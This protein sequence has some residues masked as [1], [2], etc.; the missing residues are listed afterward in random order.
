M[1]LSPMLASLADAP[2]DDPNLVY[3]PKYD[4]IRA[5][6]EVRAVEGPPP[7]DKDRRR[8]EARLWSRRG[9]D[10]TPEFPAVA[11]AL[12]E[13]A[14]R[15]GVPLVLD[16]EI[17]A[18][19]ER[20]EPAGFQ[21]LQRRAQ[22]SPADVALIVFDLLRE[23]SAD[24]RDLP[25]VERRARLERLITSE[26]TGKSTLR[27]SEMTRGNGRELYS[28]ARASGWE[29]IIAKQASSPYRSGKRTPEW[30]K[31]KIVFEQEFVIGG[32]TEPRQTRSHFGALLLGVYEGKTRRF[33]R[34][35]SRAPG[36]IHVGLA[37]TGFDEREL[38]RVMKCLRPLETTVCPFEEKPRTEERAHWIR[39]ELVAQVKFTEWTADGRLRN[40]VYLGLRDDR[41]PHQIMREAT[42]RP[43]ATVVRLAS[44]P[45]G[46]EVSSTARDRLLD[47]LREIEDSRRDSV[48]DLPN[49]GKLAVTNLSKIFWP[50]QQFTKGDLVRY[51][52]EV[53]P[54]ILPA[55][56][57]RPLVMKR[58]PNGI[59][60]KAFYQHQ[61]SRVPPGVRVEQVVPSSQDAQIAGGDLMTLLYT[62]QLAAVSQDPWFSRV[63]SPQYPD[64]VALDLD[65]MP[66]VPFAGVLDVARWI[67]DELQRLDATGFAKTSGSE[68][69]HVYIPL[70]PG[71]PYEAG[72]LFC[73][74]VATL[75]AQ[76]HPKS[77]TLERSLAAR[78]NRTYIDFLQNAPGKT[79]ASAY[80]A[81][82]SEY[83]G[84]STPLSWTEIDKGVRREDFTIKSVPAR[85]KERGDLWAALRQSKGVDLERATARIG[86]I[87]T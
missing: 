87:K 20:G 41:D 7:K 86:R 50:S 78:G 14:G 79:L 67:R 33:R 25:L 1:L 6:A 15:V 85:L 72:Q 3:E 36:L 17:V 39:P 70:P 71:T 81:R 32:W 4:G 59:R 45:G 35:S 8:W 34:D 9:N 64:Y 31:L 54:F 27:I 69:L 21:Q 55:I 28:R 84:V 83:A 47:R 12:E 11:A 73:R 44:D 29:G 46:A 26:W 53:A 57:D 30:R 38:A 5:I 37:G 43:H 58:Y 68:G 74:I 77:A 24:L 52:V 10:K 42:L 13:W 60:S 82:A 75:V 51:Y 19:N 63:Q 80:S 16:G 23:G 40:P 65:P 61:V 62:A 66:G 18:L 49:G 76:K 56:A 2:L 22:G 48:I